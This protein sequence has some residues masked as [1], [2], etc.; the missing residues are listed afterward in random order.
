MQNENGTILRVG[1]SLL[2]LFL[3]STQNLPPKTRGSESVR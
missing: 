3:Q 2:V 1:S